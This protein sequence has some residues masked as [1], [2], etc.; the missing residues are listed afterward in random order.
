MLWWSLFGLT[1]TVM[2]WQASI[3]ENKELIALYQQFREDSA[4]ETARLR[5]E[6]KYEVLDS[7]S[8]D[9]F[10]DVL[11]GASSGVDNCD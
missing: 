6:I 5:T 7:W 11:F 8:F 10:T 9:P 1:D 2:W 3:E 4:V